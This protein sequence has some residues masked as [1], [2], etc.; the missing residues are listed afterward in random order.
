MPLF[1]FNSLQERVH[2][3]RKVPNP[4]LHWHSPLRVWQQARCPGG[5]LGSRVWGLFL[6]NPSLPLLLS[7]S[8]PSFWAPLGTRLPSGSKVG[9][10]REA[11]GLSQ[12]GS[13][14]RLECWIYWENLKT[15]WG[16]QAIEKW[17]LIA[18]AVIILI[19]YVARGSF[20]R[21]AYWI[22]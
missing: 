13:C 17:F 5:N 7:S 16:M 9:G 22:I 4:P 20:F 8:P 10:S 21:V 14:S 19:S 2:S 3:P 1:S 11:R 18:L 6:R 12:M 15:N